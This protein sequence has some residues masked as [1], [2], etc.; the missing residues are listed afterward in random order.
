[1]SINVLYQNFIRGIIERGKSHAPRGLPTTEVLANTFCWEMSKPLITHQTRKLNLSFA[2]G[3]P[4]WI[5]SGDN[6]LAGISRFMKRYAN[7][8]DDGITLSGAYGPPFRDQLPY[9]I[10][11]L[12]DDPSSRQAVIS[13]WRPKP[14]PSKDIPC[15]IALQFMVR[16]GA[17]H[18]MVN[19]RSSDA[20]LGLPYDVMTFSL[21]S[22]L[23]AA[24]L[25][26]ELGYGTLF[27]GSSHIY[28]NHHTVAAELVRTEPY[29]LPQLTLRPSA[30]RLQDADG[31]KIDLLLR[32][33]TRLEELALE[34]R[35]TDD[36]SA[37]I[38]NANELLG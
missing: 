30:I 31:G 22:Y 13:I 36:V 4:H 20:W 23:V 21:M 2:F 16:G 1:M 7:Y 25:N 8:S 34:A 29:E 11:T 12:C 32:L 17:L 5:L 26:V 6:S 18:T 28:E 9:I 35:F 37:V 38:D 27:I 33:L 10:R 24:I 15:T 3:E 14:G 19:M